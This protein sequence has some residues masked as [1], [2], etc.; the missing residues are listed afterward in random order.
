M[1]AVFRHI[2]SRPTLSFAI[3]C[4]VL[5]LVVVVVI[6]SI[7]TDRP[8][9]LAGVTDE[10]TAGLDLIEDELP[11]DATVD[12]TSTSRTEACPDGSAGSLVYIDRTITLTPD[13]DA[14]AWA[15]DLAREYNAKDGWSSTVKTLGARDHLRVTLVNQT[16]LIYTLTTGSEETPAILTLRSGSRCSQA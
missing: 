1:A 10:V 15:A 11:P 4:A 9:T 5:L 2:A 16:L 13:F 12:S 7:R 6:L 3:A 8:V 14:S